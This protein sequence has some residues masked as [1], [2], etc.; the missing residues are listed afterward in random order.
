MISGWCSPCYGRNRVCFRWVGKVSPTHPQG[1]DDRPPGHLLHTDRCQGKA[2]QLIVDL[3]DLP[4][5]LLRLLQMGQVL[6]N[7]D[8]ETL[9]CLPRFHH[10]VNCRLDLDSSP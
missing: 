10:T 6:Y 2:T 9:N 5:G 7:Q 3:S 1:L 8:G 4:H